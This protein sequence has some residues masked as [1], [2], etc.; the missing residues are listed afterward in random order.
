MY[1]MHDK[2]ISI[3]DGNTCEIIEVNP[4]DTSKAYKIKDL[5]SHIEEWISEVRLER[6][7]AL[8]STAKCEDATCTLQGYINLH[9]KKIYIT[10]SKVLELIKQGAN[11]HY[12]DIYG[13]TF[14]QIAAKKQRYDLVDLLAR[15]EYIPIEKLE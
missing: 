10:Y 5:V 14:K 1:A 15:A 4:E 7:Y 9:T 3:E 12:T 2:F 11:L 13:Y 6:G 8:E